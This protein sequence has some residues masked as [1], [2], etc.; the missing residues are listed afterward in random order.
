M[1][2]SGA[3]R[4]AERVDARVSSLV[5]VRIATGFPLDVTTRSRSAASFRNTVFDDLQS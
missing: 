2:D 1:V 4:R 5:L 3:P